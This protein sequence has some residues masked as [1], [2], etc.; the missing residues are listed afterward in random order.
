MLIEMPFS[1]WS[2]YPLWMRMLVIIAVINFFTFI[3][4]DIYS[5]GSA[6]NGYQK[7]G[8]YYIGSHGSYRQVSKAFWTYSYIHGITMWI[9]HLS[10]FAGAA[11]I[12]NLKRYQRSAVQDAEIK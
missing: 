11:L 9:T 1:K 5:G 7:D 6:M 4:V 10:V 8:L 12:L 2:E 3:S